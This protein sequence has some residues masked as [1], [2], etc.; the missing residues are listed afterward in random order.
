MWQTGSEEGHLG[1][2]WPKPQQ[3]LHCVHLF[4]E[5]ARSIALEH[6]KSRIEDPIVGTSPGWTERMTDSSRLA[7]P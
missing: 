1:A 7:F 6:K 3:F 5:Y 2:T 4:E